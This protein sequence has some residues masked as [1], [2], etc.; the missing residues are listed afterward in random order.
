ML[1]VLEENNGRVSNRKAIEALSER[2]NRQIE[3]DEYEHVKEQLLSSGK[4]KKGTGRGGCIELIQCEDEAVKKETD[5][6]ENKKA[7]QESE[8]EKVDQLMTSLA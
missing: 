7:Q 4:I 8:T 1:K 2:L 6:P 5:S 3:K